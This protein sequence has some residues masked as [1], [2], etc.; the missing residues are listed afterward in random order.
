MLLPAAFAPDRAPVALVACSD[1]G[2]L[3][4]AAAI[5]WAATRDPP[6]FP[7]AIHVL[8]NQRRHGVGR[9]LLEAVVA[10]VRGEAPAVQP[11]SPLPEGSDAAAFGLACQFTVHHRIL[12]FECDVQRLEAALAPMRERLDAAGW[13]P[14]G[15]RV[16]PLH[17]APAGE[18]AHLVSREFHTDPA[19][20]LARLRGGVGKPFEPERSLVLLRD[21]AVVAA[22]LISIGAD[23][24]PDVEA[25]M[26]IP[27][28]RRGWANLLLT[29][30]MTRV[31]F[32]KW[33][34]R[35]RFYC[36]DRV[37]DTVNL[38]RR[39]GAERTRVD[40]MLLR[41]VSGA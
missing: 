12:H 32:A 6:A 16:V 26:V 39:S 34:R 1:D 23:G 40:L 38:A 8:P 37:L 20:L 22:Q 18:L 15:A 35:F 11:W 10:A 28:L 7:V 9:A 14:A 41:E 31:G 30:E 13:I 4:G 21:D 17:A 5:G 27:T 19:G 3:I 24:I 36:D 29:H 25:N 2:A 33:T